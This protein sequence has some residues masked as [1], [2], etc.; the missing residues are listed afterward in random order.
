MILI[1]SFP[2]L[3]LADVS[4]TPAMINPAA[5][6]MAKPSRIFYGTD[7]QEISPELVAAFN[8]FK[9]DSEKIDTARMI[10]M[11]MIPSS[12]SAAV[13]AQIFD[14]SASYISTTERFRNSSFGKTALQVEQTMK[15]EVIVGN[16]SGIEHKLNFNIQ[17]MQ[18]C[19]QVQY[20]GLMRAAVKYTVSSS[21][22]GLE[23]AEK[24]FDNKDLVLS[25]SYGSE[26]ISEVSLRWNF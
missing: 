4:R 11:N 18:T 6:A 26:R 13:F 16:E 21:T 8:V 5:R 14:R 23:V 3:V 10:P 25:Q 2:E 1:A 19:A 22:L 7:G 9:R 15:Q 17:A 12:N 20:S 24:I